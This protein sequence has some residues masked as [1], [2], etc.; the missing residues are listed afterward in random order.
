MPITAEGI[1]TEEQRALLLE[2]GGGTYIGINNGA[3]DYAAVALGT[4]IASPLR[5]TYRFGTMAATS[6]TFTARAYVTAGTAVLN[7]SSTTP[8]RPAVSRQI[9]ERNDS[10][11]FGLP[12]VNGELANSAVPT[13]CSVSLAMNAPPMPMLR[14]SA[15]IH[16]HEA[17]EERARKR[18]ELP[19]A[20]KHFATNLNLLARQD[21]IAPAYG[22]DDEVQQ[23]LEILSHRER[24]NSAMLIGEPGVGKTAIVEGLAHR[25][26]FQPETIPAR[27]RECQIVSLQMNT[28]VAGTMLR[29]M[30]EERIQNVIREVK[31]HPN[32]ILFI[33]EA[34]TIIGAGAR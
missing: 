21:R 2:L 10:I 27:L 32:L 22:R 34:H 30:F 33:D 6:T 9:S 31:E 19:P 5:T 25:L 16:E 11:P 8:M 23:V 17:R 24:S 4:G 28:L 20:L 1:E 26:E 3:T 18:F 15:V 7:A 12:S 14:V 13:G 29:G